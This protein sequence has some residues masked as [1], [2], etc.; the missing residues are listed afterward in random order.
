M[1]GLY[2]QN[3]ITVDHSAKYQ[4]NN[5]FWMKRSH[6]SPIKTIN[7]KK[8]KKN[9]FE[10]FLIFCHFHQKMRIFRV[11]FCLKFEY[12]GRKVADSPKMLPGMSSAQNIYRKKFG[13]IG[14]RIDEKNPQFDPPHRPLLE[15]G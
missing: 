8:L 2:V 12:L 1:G 11:F 13:D 3:L 4:K 9:I 15:R 10:F 14:T 6:I 7:D 5:N